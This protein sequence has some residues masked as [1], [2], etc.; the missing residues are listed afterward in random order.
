MRWRFLFFVA[1]S[2]FSDIV[3]S[4]EIIHI[5]CKKMLKA[6][7]QARRYISFLITMKC[8]RGTNNKTIRPAAVSTV[9]PKPNRHSTLHS[10]AMK[11]GRRTKHFAL[12]RMPNQS[13]VWLLWRQFSSCQIKNPTM[14]IFTLSLRFCL[15]FGSFLASALSGTHNNNYN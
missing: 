14:I 15:L 3:V 1:F 12:L 5:R 8:A 10:N 13:G 9:H 11:I 7:K 2:M 6:N 4:L